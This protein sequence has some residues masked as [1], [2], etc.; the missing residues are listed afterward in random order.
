MDNKL[1]Q[2]QLELFSPEY[3]NF[4]MGEFPSMTAD[5]YAAGLELTEKDHQVFE[6]GIILYLTCVLNQAEWV[7]FLVSYTSIEKPVAETA[8]KDILAGI[9]ANLLT[10]VDKMY[11]SLQTEETTNQD[12]SP[13]IT[14][15][16][17]T[18]KKPDSPENITS[19]VPKKADMPVPPPA[20]DKQPI[21]K[22]DATIPTQ[23]ES[24]V[25]KTP[26]TP[27]PTKP[28]TSPTNT[29]TDSVPAVRTMNSDSVK[30][31]EKPPTNEQSP[32]PNSAGWKTDSPNT[33]N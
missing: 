20:A 8:I 7:D 2:E 23:P 24:E 27:I 12:G 5:V 25:S 17:P 29:P 3:Q 4:V 19:D 26:L 18:T 14:P 28:T 10:E 33:A 32:K 31:T 6:N 16:P 1:L 9:D 30:A 15:L 22:A 11:Q 21:E 13:K